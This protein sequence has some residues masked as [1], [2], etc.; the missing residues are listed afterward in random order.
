MHKI[1]IIPT[2]RLE[3]YLLI[4]F[5]LAAGSASVW[6][7]QD[8]LWDIFNYHIYNPFA[9]FNGRF[10]VDV[11]PAKIHTFLNPLLDVPYYLL[12]M[13]ANDYPR[14]A[15]FLLGLPGGVLAFF[16]YK[17]TTFYLRR[18]VHWVVMCIVIAAGCSGSV[19]VAQL[20]VTSQEV[21]LAA[22][23][24]AG[25]YSL[26][27]FLFKKPTTYGL[28]GLAAFLVGAAVGLKYTQA[29][30]VF[31]LMA[32]FFSQWRYLPRPG[33]ALVWF[34]GG[35]IVGF[36]IV[37]G[38]FMARL[39]VYYGN[40]FFPFLNGIFKSPYFDPVNFEDRFFYPRTALQYFF[41]P[42]F[43]IREVN[44]LATD[45]GIRLADARMALGY[46]GGV[47][48]AVSYFCGR[49]FHKRW[50]LTYRQ[51]KEFTLWIFMGISY[52]FWLHFYSLLRY[53]VILEVLSVLLFIMALRRICKKGWL[54]FVVS[55]ALLGGLIWG[56][57]YPS[58]IRLP[59]GDKIVEFKYPPRVLPNSL[60]LY[61]E[62]GL[63]FFSPFFPAGTRFVGILL[64]PEQYDTEYSQQ[65][66]RQRIQFPSN[67][68]AYHFE[69]EIQA[70]I[71]EH[72]GP[73]YVLATPWNE[74]VSDATLAPYGLEKYLPCMLVTSNLRPKGE[75]NLCRVRKKQKDS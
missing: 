13:H 12:V 63:S 24:S 73:I 51:R 62:D 53:A 3:L 22:M 42:F 1:K 31:G 74:M 15:A 16:L 35:G 10:G 32:V 26:L 44:G 39:W 64:T 60:V 5:F 20:G 49:I 25:L 61:L 14:T 45:P 38:F 33:R 55:V 40:P 11:I 48:W 2:W 54:I 30:Y 46:V 56:T 69:R 27:I 4:T 43:W 8:L 9:L 65:T 58:W 37:N 68:Y 34:A 57:H 67:Y 47:L 72:T 19:L 71:D 17:I 52:F 66:A 29:P 75:W 6:L 59:Y 21:L 41:Y 18:S 36:L 70:A 28:A 50:E 7:G 23:V